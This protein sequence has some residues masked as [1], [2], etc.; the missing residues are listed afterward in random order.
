LV[1]RSL[2]TKAYYEDTARHFGEA[3][4]ETIIEK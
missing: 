2:I 4:E 3:I 1:S